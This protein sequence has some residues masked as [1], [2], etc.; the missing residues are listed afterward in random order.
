V[1]G[2]SDITKRLGKAV[3]AGAD[4]YTKAVT[5]SDDSDGKQAG[6]SQ[7]AKVGAA[8]RKVGKSAVSMLRK[9]KPKQNGNGK[10]TGKVLDI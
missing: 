9:S 3:R 5:G 7:G 6:K 2:F 4:T 10:G 8:A 1:A